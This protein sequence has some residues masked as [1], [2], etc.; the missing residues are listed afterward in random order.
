MSQSVTVTPTVQSI[1][2][3]SGFSGTN[4]AGDLQGTYPAPTIDNMAAARR[5]FVLFSDFSNTAVPWTVFTIASATSAFTHL[6]D[7]DTVNYV[8]IAPAI[9]APASRGWVSDRPSNVVQPQFLAGT[10]ELLFASRV[11]FN[12]NSQ[13]E[14]TCRTGFTQAHVEPEPLATKGDG[15]VNALC[16]F[17]AGTKSTWHIIAAAD[18]TEADGGTGNATMIDSGIGVTDWH[19]FEIRVD[20]AGTTARF[21]IDGTLV[22]TITGNSIP[23]PTTYTR[24]KSFGEWLMAGTVIRATSVGIAAAS[25]FDLDWQFFEY[26]IA[27]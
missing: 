1:S 19:D 15:Q 17:C 16:F 23:T 14:L 27:R 2:V 5:S 13:T 24:A 21:W 20:A 9:S 6:Y 4:A 3:A 10:Y 22:A 26:K 12:R 7:G 18:Y 11:R 8:S 25:S